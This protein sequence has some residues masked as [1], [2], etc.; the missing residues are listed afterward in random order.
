MAKTSF[1]SSTGTNPT[2]VSTIQSSLASIATSVAASEAALDS[3]TDIYLGA[4][5]S[6]PTT[7]NDGD[8]LQVGMLVFLT[9]S[10]ELQIYKS[11]GWKSLTAAGSLLVANN[12]SDLANN[13]Q[14]RKNL[15]LESNDSSFVIKAEN[16]TGDAIKVD[17]AIS[18]TSYKRGSTEIL[19]S[20]G[21]LTNV[22]LDA[23]NF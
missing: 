3:F 15:L 6:L 2:H 9:T 8:P 20:A 16:N 1:F 10:N 13:T 22:T 12:L 19:T 17:G 5:P 18:G 14:A 23:G 7:D 4:K 21:Q 11:D